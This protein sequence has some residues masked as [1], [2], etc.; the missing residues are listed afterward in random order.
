MK[1]ARASRSVLRVLSVSGVLPLHYRRMAGV[2]ESNPWPATLSAAVLPTYTYPNKNEP[3]YTTRLG[4]C[5][6]DIESR[7]TSR[8]PGSR[9][10]G[11]LTFQRLQT[12]D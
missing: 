4:F 11:K 10:S 1:S 8:A 7:P 9:L 3:T 2:R 6:G 5:S 12:R